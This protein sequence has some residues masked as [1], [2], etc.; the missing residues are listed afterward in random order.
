MVKQEVAKKEIDDALILLDKL[1][2]ELEEFNQKQIGLNAFYAMGMTT[3]EIRH[4]HFLA[5]LLNPKE[6]HGLG[7]L[8]LEKLCGKLN[9][10]SP[11]S[12]D[13][14]VTKEEYQPNDRKRRDIFIVSK[15]A[16]TT[17]TIENKIFTGTHDDQLASYE[18]AVNDEYATYKNIFIY[19]SPKGDDPIN[20][21]GALAN[22]WK[23]LDYKTLLEIVNEAKGVVQKKSINTKKMKDKLEDMLEDYIKMTELE[24]LMKDQNII[25]KSK[26]IWGK[27]SKALE[28][29]N[30]YVDSSND[31]MNYCKEK[32]FSNGFSNLLPSSNSNTL[33]YFCSNDLIGILNNKNIGYPTSGNN[34]EKVKQFHVCYRITKENG[35]FEKLISIRKIS[36][37]GWSDFKNDILKKYNAKCN[38]EEVSLIRGSLFGKEHIYADF[39][40]DA[41]KL[42]DDNLEKFFSEIKDFEN[43]L[44]QL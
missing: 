12:N 23:T 42:F 36:P 30:S 37:N 22:N 1:A 16:E 29:I 3:Q 33:L 6:T 27:H 14:I 32:V 9:M 18:K 24:V 35:F 28:I 25:A 26:E 15:D 17:I 44:N 20:A 5:W 43:F 34:A 31:I 38:T 4:S 40:Q 8:F 21:N 19:L 41:K 2:K 13:I 11:N 39:N 7:T 10:Q